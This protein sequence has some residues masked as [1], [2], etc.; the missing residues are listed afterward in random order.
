MIADP[1]QI[2]GDIFKSQVLKDWFLSNPG[3]PF[4]FYHH[5]AQ[6]FDHKAQLSDSAWIG[7]IDREGEEAWFYEYLD[8]NDYRIIVDIS[9]ER[10]GSERFFQFL[11]DR[12]PDH[13][14]WFLF[15]PEL[16]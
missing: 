8:G 9:E 5:K 11:A 10:V 3:E 7:I 12:Y 16:M 4:C 2:N 13:F 1:I 6:W 15:H 14:E